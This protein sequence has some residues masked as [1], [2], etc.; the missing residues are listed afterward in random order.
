MTRNNA[1]TLEDTLKSISKLNATILI[2][3]IGSTDDT[4]KIC[5]KYNAKIEPI[6]FNDDYS[7][8]RN[9]M[10]KKSKTRWNM[11]IE[12][13]EIL[14]AGHDEITSVTAD[15]TRQAFYMQVLK[16]SVISK[17]IRLWSNGLKFDN[18]IFETLDDSRATF[19]GSP[20]IY[21]KISKDNP[22]EELKLIELWK[23]SRPASC[24]PYYYH[25]CALLKQKKY[26]KFS[27]LAEHYL[28]HKKQGMGSI[29]MRYYLACVL[30]YA[31]NDTKMTIKYTLEC[32]V[33]RPLMAEFWCLLADVFY[34][35]GKFDKAQAFYENAIVLGQ[36]RL[37]SDDWPLEIKKY[38]EYPEIMIASCK[39]MLEQST[40]FV[41]R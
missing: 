37:S 6:Q 12:P 38:K 29:M 3:D 16:G 26:K 28:F 20:I 25:A 4:Y 33:T 40:F 30:L 35:S 31:F 24:E 1:T 13:W 10:L 8:V 34:K 41:R 14:I 27:M 15:N 22:D 39:E 17:Q 36:N 5:K 23:K 2:G 18:P 9:L 21:T 19:L 11:H 7:V 32:I